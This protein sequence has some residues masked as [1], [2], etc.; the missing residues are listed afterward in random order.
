[1]SSIP[2]S[3]LDNVPAETRQAIL[4][5][6]GQVDSTDLFNL[7]PSPSW[8]G[9][10]LYGDLRN[11]SQGPMMPSPMP[12]ALPNSLQIPIRMGSLLFYSNDFLGG[13]WS[14]EV[15]VDILASRKGSYC[16]PKRLRT[17]WAT[18]LSATFGPDRKSV[19]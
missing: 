1:M 4:E 6:I 17:G 14:K 3:A 10:K 2:A 19:V 15:V 8:F 13:N 7:L 5:E 9:N 16:L 11:S 12:M 18:L